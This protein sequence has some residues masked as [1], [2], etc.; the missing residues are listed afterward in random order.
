MSD[1]AAHEIRPTHNPGV[2]ECD[3]A[4][5]GWAMLEGLSGD[6]MREV[7]KTAVRR[8]FRNGDTLF[9]QGDPGDSLHFLDKGH[10]AIRVVSSRGDQLTFDLLEPGDAFGEQALLSPDNRR[11][12]SAVS[13]G[14]VETL[15]LRRAEF[16][17]LR[18]R[19]PSVTEVLVHALAAQVRRL[20][21]Q[22]TDAHTLP[23]DDRVLK[24]LAR[25]VDSFEVDGVETVTI[26]LTQEDLA[27][28]AGTTRPTANRALQPLV[29]AGVIELR[30]G[31]IEVMDPPRLPRIR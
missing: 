1:S 20:S 27:S 25:L 6:E 31:R 26:P 23:A 30:R 19:H 3:N 14:D 18:Q 12:A 28:L 11:T 16:N 10:V 17:D 15:M 8:R 29:A 7:L 4:H 5:V 2:A 9:H 21:D 24:Q 22:V 13:V